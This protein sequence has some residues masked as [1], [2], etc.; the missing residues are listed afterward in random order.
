MKLNL[1]VQKNSFDVRNLNLNLYI[2]S[3]ILKI[4]II[5]F[6]ASAFIIGCF[7]DD[8]SYFQ[9]MFFTEQ[10]NF[11]A[12]VVTTI[13]LILVIWENNKGAKKVTLLFE[14]IRFA[15]ATLITITCLI[16]MCILMPIGLIEKDPQAGHFVWDELILHAVVP[17]LVV[18]DVLVF[19]ND[20]II[21]K[22]NVL[23]PV[24]FMVFYLCFA[25]AA[26]YLHWS[27][28]VVYDPPH[29]YPY[30]FLNFESH[31]GWFGIDFVFEGDIS[32]DK[33]AIGSF[34]WILFLLG[35]VL[36]FGFLYRSIINKR[37][38]QHLKKV[39]N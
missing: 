21:W 3:I 33:N 14:Q 20:F 36:S 31:T 35:L 17:P 12:L 2:T 18:I 39:I 13:S 37:T 6:S 25:I 8:N 26:F 9:L 28:N 4:F 16:F 24:G 19:N 10:S 27:F 23:I 15:S 7:F 34:Y 32:H 1:K 30:F 11:I 22:K 29:N 5:N 38:K